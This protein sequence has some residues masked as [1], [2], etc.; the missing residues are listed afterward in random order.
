MRSGTYGASDK[1]QLQ[2]YEQFGFLVGL[3]RFDSPMPIDI[4]IQLINSSNIFALSTFPTLDRLA[5][6]LGDMEFSTYYA[7]LE[8]RAARNPFNLRLITEAGDEAD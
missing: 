1:P 5:S 2:N 7:I 8:R 3:I 4:I 6:G